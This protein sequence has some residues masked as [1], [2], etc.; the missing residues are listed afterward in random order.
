M[1]STMLTSSSLKDDPH[2]SVNAQN[3]NGM[4]PRIIIGQLK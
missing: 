4:L 3:T 2:G 1:I